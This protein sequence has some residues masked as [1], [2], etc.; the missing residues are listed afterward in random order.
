MTRHSIQLVMAGLLVVACMF[1]PF[2]PGG[3]DGL[4][5]TLSFMAQGFA[6]AGLLLVPIGAFW[7]AY[8][9]G[10]RR[11]IDREWSGKDM[12]Y[13]FGWAA[14]GVST[15]VAIVVSLGAF[16]KVG[17][18]LGLAVVALWAYC[19]FQLAARLKAISPSEVRA[20]NPAPL[21]LL[22]LPIVAAGFKFTLVGPAAEFS[23]NRVIDNSAALIAD[24][25]RFRDSHG[26]YPVSLQSLHE[27]Y[28]PGVVGVQRYHYEPNGESYNVYFEHFPAE[29]DVREIVMYNPRGE[30]RFTSHNADLLE[31]TGAQL[32]LR[33]GDSRVF[34]A[35]RP[36]WKYFLFD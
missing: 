13:W 27:D 7:L 31:F 12:G 3:Y 33:R 5:V 24:I 19:A 18:S 30:Q 11:R 16:E 25:E 34:N 10:T 22:V 29:F 32:D 28:K 4:A 17:L 6:V 23:R 36:N 8:E 15:L 14:I 21:Y 35:S 2:F 9:L 1:L 20:F 26:R